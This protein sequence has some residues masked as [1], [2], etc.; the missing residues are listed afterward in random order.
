M[1]TAMFSGLIP[2][3][4][5][6]LNPD[7]SIDETALERI[8]CYQIEKGASGLVALGGTGEATA[9]SASARRRVIQI[10]VSA[11]A[12]RVPVIA[13][14]LDS[15]F[16]GALDTG[17]LYREAGA[18]GLMVIPPYYSRPDQD[19]ILRYFRALAPELRLPIIFYDNPFR[20]QIITTPATIARMEQERL[21]IGMK[22]SNTDLYHL[23][24]LS[25][26]V[27]DDFSL[28]SGQDTLFV[29]QVILGAK[30]GV[31]TSAALLP[32]YWANVQTL[33][34]TGRVQEALA[35]QAMLNPLMDALFN[36]QFPESVRQ[37]FAM[38][39][40]PIG[41]SLPPVGPL[42]QVGEARLR[43]ALDALI[44]AGILHRI[45]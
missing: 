41:R 19:G 6:P 2:A 20:S 21:V 14:V 40:L 12:K 38:L 35:A 16:G 45:R 5:T 28:L 10:T 9:L 18:D 13:G 3:F 42:S 27:S 7:S 30:G 1:A 15:G 25:K 22:A 34:E 37:A 32:D 33:A 8:V 26:L 4:P 24:V 43:S 23:D 17:L 44:H 31:L 29:Q 36:E 39:G 11:A